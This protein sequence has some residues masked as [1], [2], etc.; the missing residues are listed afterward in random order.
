MLAVTA[1]RVNV[2]NA[3]MYRKVGLD[4]T[5]FTKSRKIFTKALRGGACLTRTELAAHLKRQVSRPVAFIWPISLCVLN[6]T[7]L[8]VAAHCEVNSRR[9]PCSRNEFLRRRLSTEKKD[10][11]NS[12]GA[13]S[14]VVVQ[15]R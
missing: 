10:W 6:W 7:E 14:T 12:P 5:V 8:S 2:L 11:S 15:R 1:P 9:M 3:H 4:E 13:T